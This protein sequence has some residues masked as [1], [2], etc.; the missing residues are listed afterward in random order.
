MAL[1]RWDPLHDLLSLQERINRLFEHG[2]AGGQPEGPGLPAGWSPLCDV[3]ETDASYV[4][5]LELPGLSRDDVELGAT[6][7]E[8]VV[9]G[10]RRAACD[11]RPDRF[12]RMERSYGRFQRVLRFE[13]ELAAGGV[14]AELRDGVLR[15]ELPKAR[16]NAERC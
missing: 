16:A 13:H 1:A 14:T 8:L 10:R 6:S 5:E 2:L 9:R 15:V 3:V 7:H 11:V 12:H 4:V